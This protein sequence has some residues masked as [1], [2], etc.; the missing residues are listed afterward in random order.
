MNASAWVDIVAIGVAVIFA[1]L[2]AWRG[3][4]PEIFSMLGIFLGI[5]F[6]GQWGAAWSADVQNTF[7][8]SGLNRSS[9]ELYTSY[10]IFLICFL[11][12]GFLAPAAL[13]RYRTPL[14]GGLRFG[15]AVL[16]LLNAS[17]VMTWLLVFLAATGTTGVGIIRNSTIGNFLVTRWINWSL[18]A[19][20]GGLLLFTI[21]AAASRSFR[22]LTGPEAQAVLGPPAARPAVSPYLIPPSQTSYPPAQPNPYA[23]P[24]NNAPTRMNTAP[25]YP[26]A[27]PYR[28][29]PPAYPQ[30]PPM[31][32]PFQPPTPVNYT[33]PQYAAS[34]SGPLPGYVPPPISY[35]ANQASQPVPPIPAPY[36][37]QPVVEP[38]APPPPLVITAKPEPVSEFTRVDMEAPRSTTADDAASLLERRVIQPIPRKRQTGEI[39]PR[40]PA[41]LPGQAQ[42]P[43]IDSHDYPS[44]R[45]SGTQVA[46]AD[47]PPGQ[48]TR[49]EMG[50]DRRD[51]ETSR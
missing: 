19:V 37:P 7:N 45:Y 38:F 17:L 24:I 41:S 18:L 13:V 6:V 44:E 10:G 42:P 23:P 27:Q 40:D 33:P 20:V 4:L 50:S 47:V 5:V 46:S 12:V 14:T 2:G 36:Q 8:S 22:V 51:E 9:A 1:A 21:L 29:A 35:Q 16:G 30:Y 15:G 34:P 49:F 3:I 28:P 48:P 26:P 31:P 43:L 11:L 39:E 25:P 32:P